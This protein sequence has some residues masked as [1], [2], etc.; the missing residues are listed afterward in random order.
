MLE[1]KDEKPADARPAEPWIG[2]DFDWD[3][4]HPNPPEK[5]AAATVRRTAA[6]EKSRASALGVRTDVRRL[7]EDMEAA[8]ADARKREKEAAS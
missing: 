8:L 7:A 4:P 3:A 2:D 6:I 1:T 5:F